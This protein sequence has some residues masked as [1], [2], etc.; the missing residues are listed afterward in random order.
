MSRRCTA[1]F[2][3]IAASSATTPCATKF[4]SGYVTTNLRSTGTKELK[5]G[6]GMRERANKPAYPSNSF[7]VLH[8]A[9]PHS[10]PRGDRDISA[11][12]HSS[13]ISELAIPSPQSEN[14]AEATC[15]GSAIQ[16]AAS[17]SSRTSCR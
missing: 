16:K 5:S 9:L 12:A 10:S 15:M 14:S 6:C 17:F 13:A 1:G 2:V 7:P 8:Q 4:D 11:K 3:M